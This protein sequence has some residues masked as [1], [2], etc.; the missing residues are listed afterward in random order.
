MP[1]QSQQPQVNWD[2]QYSQPQW[3]YSGGGYS[4][5]GGGMYGYGMQ[6]AL[7]GNQINAYLNFPNAMNNAMSQ[8]F[9]V[10]QG[11]QAASLYNNQLNAGLGQAQMLSESNIM[12][13]LL[14]AQAQLGTAALQNQGQTDMLANPMFQEYLRG[15]LGTSVA[16]AQGKNNLAAI[17]AKG[18][19]A[20]DLFGSMSGLFGGMGG[21]GAGAANILQGFQSADGSQRAT[22]PGATAAPQMYGGSNPAMQ[23]AAT[24]QEQPGAMQSYLQQ[25]GARGGVGQQAQAGAAA[26]PWKQYLQDFMAQRRN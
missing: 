25:I 16:D 6:D 3:N 19:I 4:G 13:A 8:M 18:S 24:Q 7:M 2:M 22:M 17:Q 1:L 23:P 21:V 20:K 10:N 5:G 15:N 12:Q 14:Q 9:A 11:N 26:Q